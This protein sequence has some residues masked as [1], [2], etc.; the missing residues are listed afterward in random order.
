ML[1][2]GEIWQ[3]L[4][5]FGRLLANFGECSSFCGDFDEFYVIFKVEFSRVAAT[6]GEFSASCVEFSRVFGKFLTSFVHCWR[7]FQKASLRLVLA[8]FGEYLA[9]F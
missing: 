2:S 9:S 5:T 4:A 8:S 7:D 3:V 6:F 1:I